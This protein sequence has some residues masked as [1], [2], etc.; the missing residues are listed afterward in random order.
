M[1]KF[2][3][4]SEHLC[5]LAI[6]FAANTFL[7]ILLRIRDVL[8]SHDMPFHETANYFKNFFKEFFLTF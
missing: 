6:L 2:G 5:C 3:L 7:D 4:Q 1:Q 8:T